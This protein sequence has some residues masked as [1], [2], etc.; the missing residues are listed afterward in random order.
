[1]KDALLASFGL[2]GG[3][4]VLALVAGLF[5]LLSVEVFLIGLSALTHP[6]FSEILVLALLAAIG[7]QIAKTVTYVGGVAALERGSLAAR[8]EKHRAKIE[9]WNK[10]PHL[11]LALAGAFGIPPMILLGFIAH[12]LMRIRFVPFTLIVFVTR[13]GRFVVVA[14][15]P[16]LL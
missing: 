1:M 15:A 3:T 4:L 8:I 13:F 14:G 5:P 10:A 12:P 7:H 2:Y 11:V 16:L 6:S 9:R